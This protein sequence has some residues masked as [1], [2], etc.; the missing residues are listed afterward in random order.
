MSKKRSNQRDLATLTVAAGVSY[1]VFREYPGLWF[2]VPLWIAVVMIWI[3]FRMHTWCDYDLGPRNCTLQAN[4]K[5]GGCRFHKRLKRDAAWAAVGMRNPGLAFRI[6]WMNSSQRS[7]HRVGGGPG[8]D[9]D[10]GASRSE[11]VARQGAYNAT[12]WIFTAVSAVA[13]I[14]MPLIAP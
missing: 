14:V 10:D 4:G 9:N 8:F 6:T 2:L 1:I 12:M 5:L 13:A 11:Q 7:G 3:L